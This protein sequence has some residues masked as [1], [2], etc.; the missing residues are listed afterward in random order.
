[1]FNILILIS[2]LGIFTLSIKYY[3]NNYL[4]N[5]VKMKDHEYSNLSYNQKK[6]LIK[7]NFNSIK[8]RK[9]RLSKQHNNIYKQDPRDIIDK[10]LDLNFLNKVINIDLENKTIHVEALITYEN[11]LDYTLQYNLIPQIVPEL[12]TLTVGGTISGVGLESSS[13]K[14]GLV[15]DMV[16]EFDIL[17][18]TG[19][20]LTINK[21]NNKEL[22]YGLPNTYGTLGYVLSAKLKLIDSKP[23]VHIKNISFNNP[24]KF[25]EEIKKYDNDNPDNINF[26]DGMLLNKNELFLMKGKM[27]EEKPPFLNKYIRQIYYKTISKQK[28]DY[29]T[30][31]D[32][33]W[34]YDSNS[35][36]LDGL[37][38]NKYLRYFFVNL[39]SSYKLKKIKE[40]S[41]FNLFPKNNNT[42]PITNDLALKLKN[43]N[44]FLEWY[45]EKISVYPT[46]ICP[47][48]CKNDYTF[49][50]CDNKLELDFGI[51]F[52][53]RKVKENNCNDNYYKKLIDDKMYS[54]K[55]IKGLYSNTFL[56]E[57]KFWELYDPS[58]KYSCL[59]NKYDPDNRFSNL[60]EKAVKNK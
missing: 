19:N 9:I 43:F 5:Y 14:Y 45:D 58:N 60:F 1:M 26:L 38:Q 24:N 56:P 6:K 57:D 3:L 48:I 21:D 37:I 49:F 31:K 25:I 28:E 12:K 2:Y 30:I 53:V 50:K 29:M 59:K 16:Y 40:L 22:F 54:M 46:W 39:L 52:G 41:I 36:Y 27:T 18:G 15:P 47:Y 10:N 44:N 34:R 23:F 8:S 33:I 17:T 35:F 11:L 42:E 55:S 32:Y 20:I 13:F 4:N 7:S 51:G